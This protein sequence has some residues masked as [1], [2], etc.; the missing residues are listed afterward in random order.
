MKNSRSGFTLIELLF[1]ASISVVILGA[2]LGVMMQVQDTAGVFKM[3]AAARAEAERAVV[4]VSRELGQ[5][6]LASLGPLP[7]ASIRYRVAVDADRDGTALDTKG[8]VE[9]S[10]ERIIQRDT[11][12]ANHDGIGAEQL[13]LING[14]LVVVLANGLAPDKAQEGAAVVPGLWFEP[15]PGGVRA[16]VRTE[17]TTRPRQHL[18]AEELA[19]TIFM[20]NP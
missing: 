7:G 11:E 12:D 16:T 1:A 14:S 2:A 4:A 20:R 13:V 18:L 15:V 10:A 5:A 6:S 17:K 3:R 9:W 8:Q 19:E